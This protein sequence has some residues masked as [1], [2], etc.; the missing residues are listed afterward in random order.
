MDDLLPCDE[1][2]LRARRG[3]LQAA[4][5]GVDLRHVAV[6]HFRDHLDGR[7]RVHL[8]DKL[9][10]QDFHNVLGP[11]LMTAEGGMVRKDFVAVEKCTNLIGI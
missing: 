7:V 1:R 8:A 3:S 4:R 5:A 10:V 6:F 11:V 9:P 2:L